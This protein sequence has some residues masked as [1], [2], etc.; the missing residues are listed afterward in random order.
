MALH[1]TLYHAEHLVFQPWMSIILTHPQLALLSIS[2]VQGGGVVLAKILG[3]SECGADYCFRWHLLRLAIQWSGHNKKAWTSQPEDPP[4]P[5]D[6]RGYV[7]TLIST[8]FGP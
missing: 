7:A 8:L 6:G 3:P 1:C 2:N 5:R 4:P